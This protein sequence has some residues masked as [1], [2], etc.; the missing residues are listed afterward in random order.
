MRYAN[1]MMI[2]AKFASE[3]H[4]MFE[5]LHDELDAVGLEIHSSN[6]KILTS[7]NDLDVGSLT[8]RS[9][10]LAI[11]HVEILHQYLDRLVTLSANRCSIE[12]SNQIR[13]AWGK[14]AQ[15][16]KWLTNR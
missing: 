3:L 2:V 5:F 7:F 16:H 13:A 12:V 6:S 15:H 8:I 4:E 11:L 14:F 9:F 1:D 10:N